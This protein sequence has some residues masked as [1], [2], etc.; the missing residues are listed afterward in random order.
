MIQTTII[1]NNSTVSITIPKN[2]IGK[3]V[4]AL[5]YI[6]EEITE[7]EAVISTQKPSDFFGTL[8]QEEGANMH[9]HIIES[10]NEWNRDI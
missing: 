4:H 9:L 3:K 7:S 5:I 8:T 10:R 2:Y 6:D 1:P